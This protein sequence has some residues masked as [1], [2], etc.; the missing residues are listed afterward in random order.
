L[1]FIFALGALTPAGAQTSFGQETTVALLDLQQGSS[2]ESL[3]RPLGAGGYELQDGTWVSFANWYD[4]AWIDMQA[5]FLVQ[6]TK[7]FG[8]LLGASTGEYAQKYRIDPSFRLGAVI[9]GHP[10]TNTTLSLTVISTFAGSFR[11]FPCI[12]DYGDIGGVQPV[13]CRLAA[14]ELPPADTLKY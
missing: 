5:D 2:L 9:Q 10:S 13:N 8:V 11:E 12:A 14:T 1:V 3:T 6:F 7:D 4:P